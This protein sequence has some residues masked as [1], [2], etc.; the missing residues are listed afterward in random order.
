MAFIVKEIT[1]TSV[2]IRGPWHHTYNLA[3]ASPPIMF[4]LMM[5]L[6][7]ST[8]SILVWQVFI[9]ANLVTEGL[10]QLIASPVILLLSYFAAVSCMGNV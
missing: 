10:Q 2:R 3:G 1:V 9:G 4:P 8:L 5:S 7:R 6:A